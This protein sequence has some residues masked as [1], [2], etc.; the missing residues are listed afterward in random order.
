MYTIDS[1]SNHPAPK[2]NSKSN[3][4]VRLRLNKMLKKKIAANKSNN[5]Q[6]VSFKLE[7][8][9]SLE[10]IKVNNSTWAKKE[11]TRCVSPIIFENWYTQKQSFVSSDR[12]DSTLS[13]Y[14]ETISGQTFEEETFLYNNQCLQD[15]NNDILN[16]NNNETINCNE[17]NSFTSSNHQHKISYAQ[18]NKNISRCEDFINFPA[19]HNNDH[20]EA[21]HNFISKRFA[22]NT[23]DN[24]F[25]ID[26]LWK[27]V[28]HQQLDFEFLNV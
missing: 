12:D 15:F 21:P 8:F 17:I 10:G 24:L 14:Q 7:K 13:I 28:K 26:F 4:A 3:S 18:D 6:Y 25:G 11:D 16:V 22:D 1:S 9:K 20:G 5:N 23:T 2:S 27:I 19:M